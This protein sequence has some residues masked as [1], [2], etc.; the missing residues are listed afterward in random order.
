MK[1]VIFGPPGSGKGTYA[2]R[3]SPILKIPQISTGDLFRENIKNETTLGKKVKGILD[4][5]ELVPDD[6]TLA[7]LKE[8]LKK[9]DCKNGFILDGYP[10][11]LQQVKDLEK[12]TSIDVVINLDV[13]DWVIIVRLSN[14]VTCSKC[15]TIFNL[16]FLKPKKEGVCDKCGGKLV[17]RKD[18]DKEV[19]QERLDVYRKQTAPLIDYYEKKGLLKNVSCDDPGIEPGIVVNQ[20]LEVLKNVNAGGKQKKTMM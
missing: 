9:D 20:I 4:K 6:V 16:K 18:D 13:P 15:G 1:I 5:G 11:T 19:I 8:R 12:V 2:S 17:H 3:I 10:R 14:R 7:M